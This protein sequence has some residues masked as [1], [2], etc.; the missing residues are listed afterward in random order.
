MLCPHDESEFTLVESRMPDNTPPVSERTTVRRLAKRG[1]YDRDTIHTIVDEA[2][3]CHVGFVDE[4]QPFVIPTTH[5]RVGDLIYLHGSRQNR[6]LQCLSAGVPACVTVTLLDA[7]VLARSAFHHSMNYRS[8]VILGRGREVTE[9]D[10][11]WN[12]LEAL[13][14]HVV[15][16]RWAEARQPSENELAATTVVAIPL[17]ESSAKIRSGPPK[18]DDADYS[19]SIWAGLLPLPM[20]PGVPVPDPQLGPDIALPS[21]V[22]SYRRK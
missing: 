5:A 2:L 8:V 11:K 4:G 10:E 17:D 14:E 13:V 12:A 22:A 21:Y 20:V 6:M 3:V 1:A 16:G 15:P 7:L 18:D 9:R 19:M